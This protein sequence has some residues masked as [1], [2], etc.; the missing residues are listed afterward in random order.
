MEIRGTSGG[1]TLSTDATL[2]GLALVDG[3]GND[4]PLDTMFASDDHEYE[5]TVVNDIDTVTLTA[6]KN[7]SN[8]M[9]VITNDDDTSTPDEAELSLNVGSN[10]LTL[11]VTAEDGNTEL[12]YTITVERAAIPTLVSNTNQTSI[13]DSAHFHAQIFETGANADGYTVSEVDVYLVSGSG[14]STSVKIRENNSSDR[15]G[16]LVATLTNPGTLTSNRLNTFTAPAA[17][18]L[19][20][21]KTYWITTNE[22]ISSN[23]ANVGRVGGTGETGE[24]G[25]SIGDDSLFR[26][27]ET[28]NWSTSGNSLMIEIRGTTGGYTA[29]TDATLSGLALV[30]VT[31]T[32]PSHW[33]SSPMITSTRCLWS[34]GSTL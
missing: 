2:S 29:S 7:D 23:R 26:A 19:A 32:T 5:A 4:I 27:A 8:A 18:T 16:D 24:P 21:S 20:A 30:D 11:T 9:V 10:T 28:S 1:T 17:T 34:T 33:P 25:W 15:P 14:R 3:N 12:T 31:T 22:G 13:G 6:T